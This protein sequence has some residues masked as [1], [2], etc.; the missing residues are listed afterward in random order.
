ME[1][2]RD[3]LKDTRTS[4]IPSVDAPLKP[5][6]NL[7]NL[8]LRRDIEVSFMDNFHTNTIYTTPPT[9]EKKKSK[10]DALDIT[11]RFMKWLTQK[12]HTVTVIDYDIRNGSEMN[13]VPFQASFSHQPHRGFW[14]SQ[15]DSKQI[16]MIQGKYILFCISKTH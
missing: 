13:I 9:E 6:E 1:E 11:S 3:V 4:Y 15:L 16:R 8:R 14:N 7:R 12:N 5:S 10:E 2:R